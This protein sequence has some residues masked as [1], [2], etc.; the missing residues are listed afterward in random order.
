MVKVAFEPALA[1]RKRGWTKQTHSMNKDREAGK[2]GILGSSTTQGCGQPSS[3]A[4]CLRAW[5]SHLT[6]LNFLICGMGTMVEAPEKGYPFTQPRLSSH[7][8]P[9]TVLGTV[10]G[11]RG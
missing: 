2:P 8:V 7:S 4:H 5:A 11:T 3:T 9:G 6:S 1:G 10:I